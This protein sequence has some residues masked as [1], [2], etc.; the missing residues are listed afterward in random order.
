MLY[1]WQPGYGDPQLRDEPEFIQL[2]SQSGAVLWL[3]LDGRD[4]EAIATALPFLHPVTAQRFSARPARAFL[5]EFDDYLHI[6]LHQIYYTEAEEVGA[7]PCHFILGANFLI[8]VHAKP[9]DS[10][11][12]FGTSAPPAR[13]FNQGSDLLF[14]FLAEPLLDQ[15]FV[16][17]DAIAE[18]TEAVEDRIFPT[19]DQTLL[20]DLFRLKKS[21]IALR[22]TLAPIREV[23]SLLSRRENPFVD[24]Q[25]LPFISHLYDQ[26]IRLHEIGDSQRE[27]VAGA[28]EIYLTTLSNRMNEVM[29][30]LT[31]VSTII[32][33]LTL[34]VGYY[35]MNFKNFAELGWDNG[36]PFVTGL[37]VLITA[38]MLWYFKRRHWL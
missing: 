21:L 9:I 34:I 19:P 38:L 28:L 5:D 10:L 24:Q 16:I 3:D 18:R 35:G 7:E 1:L 33:P 12:R 26:L 31:I 20:N 2:L 11:L 6:L 27:I 32:L 23:F 14:Y 36:I 30:T 4:P 25:A 22:K 13:Y 17:L 8:T 15:A 29:K 37:M